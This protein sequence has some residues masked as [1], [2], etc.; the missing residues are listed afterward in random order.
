MGKIDGRRFYYDFL[1]D[2]GNSKVLQG[3]LVKCGNTKSCGCLQ[4]EAASI[5]RKSTETPI[6][7]RFFLNFK[8]TDNFLCWLWLGYKDANGYG[9]IGQKN[10]SYKAHRVSWEINNQ[11][12][13]PDGMYVC[14][15]CDNPSCVNPS[16]LFLGTPNDNVQ[17]MMKKGRYV[18]GGKPNKGQKNGR[19]LLTNKQA[20]EII[21]L[22]SKMKVKDIAKK[23]SISICQASK[24]INKKAWKC[25]HVKPTQDKML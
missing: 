18:S 8:K 14:H 3:T 15:K 5:F 11:K 13:I 19:A 6:E 24:I 16:H 22:S 2:C 25:L 12:K 23:F 1:C 20:R 4:K 21:S 17:D 9:I 7:K 10:K